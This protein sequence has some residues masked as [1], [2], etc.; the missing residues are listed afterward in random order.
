PK[1]NEPMLDA[2]IALAMKKAA[3][4]PPRALG[5]L[6]APARIDGLMALRGVLDSGDATV[7]DTAVVT[8]RDKNLLDG[9]AKVL[10]RLAAS[11]RD[12]GARLA[13]VVG[14]HLDEIERLCGEARNLAALQPAAIQARITQAAADLMA[15][16]PALTPERL[17]QEAALLA[18]KADV[19]EE[20]DR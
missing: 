14:G 18:L 7:L 20:L 6:L 4:L 1:V 3:L 11:R 12:E 13:P 10:E 5:S 9:A 17:A 19:R 8:A 16:I 15:G 2:V